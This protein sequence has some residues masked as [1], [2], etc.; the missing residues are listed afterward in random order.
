MLN[1]E[2][3]SKNLTQKITAEFLTKLFVLNE[4]E[5]DQTFFKIATDYNPNYFWLVTIQD[6]PKDPCPSQ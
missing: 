3:F 4:H 2:I 1:F 5:R 6:S